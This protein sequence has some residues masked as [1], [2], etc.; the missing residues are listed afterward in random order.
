M[1]SSIPTISS[2]HQITWD[3][4]QPVTIFCDIDDTV[5][6]DRHSLENAFLTAQNE[7]DEI[8][9]LEIYFRLMGK[10]EAT[11]LEGFLAL[12]ERL[13]AGAP[14]NELCF[15]T[16]RGMESHPETKEHLRSVGIPDVESYRIFYTN[17][18]CEKGVY[19]RDTIFGSTAL[20][21]S[22]QYIFVDDNELHLQSVHTI[23]PQIQCYRFCYTRKSQHRI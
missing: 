3:P 18:W 7:P 19:L 6:S 4:Q 15:L 14:T 11:D 10:H 20:P 16:A 12:R 1:S 13:K 23:F 21:S 9:R 22:I 8:K 17:N 5:L 2:F